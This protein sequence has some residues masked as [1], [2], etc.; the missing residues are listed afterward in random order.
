MGREFRRVP[1][2]FNWPLN[3]VWWGFTEIPSTS[4]R[5]CCATGTYRGAC[6]PGCE[7]ERCVIPVVPPP[8]GGAYQYW[9]TTSEGSPISPPFATPREL[10]LW[11]TKNSAETLTKFEI[12][13]AM[14]EGGV[15]IDAPR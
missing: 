4:C 5:L 2:N 11:L 12:W 9:E 6:C 3:E 1:I 10:A 15:K 14:I 8:S 13:L 7:G